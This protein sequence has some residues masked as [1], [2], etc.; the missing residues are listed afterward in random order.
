MIGQTISHY[1]I[2]EKLGGGGMGVVYK[3][4]DLKLGRF[5]ALKFLPEDPADDPSALE[6]FK[7][8]ARTASSLNHHNICTVHDIDEGDGHPFIVMELLE[9]QTLKQR[10]LGPRLKLELLLN[11]AIQITDALEAAHSKGIIHRDI[12]PANIFITD[13]NQAKLLDFG[14]AKL[15]HDRKRMTQAVGASSVATAITDDPLTGSRV[16]PGTVAYMSPEQARGES[17]DNRSDLFSFGAVLYE[18]VT[19]TMPFKGNTSAV[20]FDAILNRVPAPAGGI[21]ADLPSELDRIISKAL[22]KDPEI[23]YQSARE[24]LV[25]LRRHRQDVL[26]GSLRHASTFNRRPGW[27]ISRR[28]LVFGG[29]LTAAGLL[30]WKRLSRFLDEE[31]PRYS[32]GQ[33]QLL[34]LTNS[35]NAETAAIS[36]DG[37][38]VAHVINEAGRQG[39]WLRQVATAS[40]VSIVPPAEVSYRWVKVSP[41]G[42]Y[43]FYV[44]WDRTKRSPELWQVPLLGNAGAARRILDDVSSFPS[45]SPD[46]QR[47]ALIE[48][49]DE[50][51]TRLVVGNI[52]GT[53]FRTVFEKKEDGL[54]YAESGPVWAPDGSLICPALVPGTQGR[55]SQ[56]I[57]VDLNTSKQQPLN[58]SRW[59]YIGGLES[60]GA[61]RGLVAVA[62]EEEM[63]PQQLWHVSYSGSQAVRITNDLNDY[64]SISATADAE[65][66]VTVRW[67]HRVNLSVSQAN[68]V[69]NPLEVTS[70]GSR[71]AT[72]EGIAWTPD[73]RIVYRSSASGSQDIWI[74]DADG[75]NKRQLT[76]NA[77]DNM[78]PSVSADG[79]TLVFASDRDGVWNIWRMNVEGG[80]AK[81]LTNGLGETFP[82]CSPAGEWLVY[83]EGYEPLGEYKISKVS[84]DGGQPVPLTPR[85]AIRPTVSPDGRFIAYF[86]MD[87]NGWRLAV[88]PSSGGSPI[89]RFPIPPSARSRYVRWT[90]DARA[91]AY[92]DDREA[93]N[94]WVQTISGG[95]PRAW[96]NFR[97]GQIFYFDWSRDGK[98]LAFARGAVTRDVVMLQRIGNK[99]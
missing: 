30:S 95:S 71:S 39:L 27:L 35:G 63:S 75:R 62:G 61:G 54:L 66:L 40:D 87:R 21:R 89:H 42:N 68:S 92:I 76:A 90:P 28:T 47:I 12:K 44:V 29:A 37:R 74:M 15:I 26:T 22:E 13:R 5:V 11:L 73:G 20:L 4:E 80:P 88:I 3:A 49:P 70:E 34:R 99:Y 41:D 77:G 55:Y 85:V 69:E 67:E 52:D 94:L 98:R 19:G 25:D 18:M 93:S 9:G 83:Q 2:L 60:L 50:V 31:L 51:T 33:V 45:L 86:A 78:H 58:S 14:L 57:R 7:R 8:E 36:P 46:G 91:L 10:L 16:T 79:R 32:L 72:F 56:L 59:G 6:R 24:V 17:L 38:Y 43:L 23:R 65:K 96:T 64:W 97:S 48:D 82:S 1:R 84:L 81:K 53:G